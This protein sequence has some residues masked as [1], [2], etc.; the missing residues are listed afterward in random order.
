MSD[1]EKRVEIL[2]YHMQLLLNMSNRNQYPFDFMI[3]AKGLSK[4]EVNE[5]MNLC[6]ELDRQY[7]EQKAQGLLYYTDLLTLF[8]GQLNEKLDVNETIDAMLK[9][10]MFKELM[11]D[12]KRLRA[13]LSSFEV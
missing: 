13:H 2:E 7:K 4:Q 6:Q 11:A 10:G 9:Q 1:L 5:L 8:A 12:F 3:V